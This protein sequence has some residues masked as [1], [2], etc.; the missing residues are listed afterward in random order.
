M[1]SPQNRAELLEMTGRADEARQFIAEQNAEIERR[2]AIIKNN[3][4]RNERERQQAERLATKKGF[5]L[6]LLSVL[7]REPAEAVAYLWE[8]TL[9]KGGLSI[10]VAKPKAG[11][12]TLARNLALA[13][14]NGQQSFL[15]RSVTASGSVVLTSPP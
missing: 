7:Y 6:T 15:G 8:N 3:A 12:S 11:K 10:L 13:V 4:E 5:D 1:N 2:E 9:I 14:A